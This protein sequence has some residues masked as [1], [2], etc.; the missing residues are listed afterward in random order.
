MFSKAQLRLEAVSDVNFKTVGVKKILG[1][2][3]RS[4]TLNCRFLL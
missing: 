4:L 1:H 2:T 3:A